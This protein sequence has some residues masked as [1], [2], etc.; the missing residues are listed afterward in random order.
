VYSTILLESP[1]TENKD[2]NKEIEQISSEPVAQ[3]EEIFKSL[4]EL[5]GSIKQNWGKYIVGGITV[6]VMLL[7]AHKFIQVWLKRITNQISAKN[8]EYINGIMR[9]LRSDSVIKS[10]FTSRKKVK[11]EI[12]RYLQ[13]LNKYNIS[14]QATP[15]QANDKLRDAFKRGKIT[16]REL[17]EFS[18]LTKKFYNASQIPENKAGKYLDIN[19]LVRKYEFKS[20]LAKT[21]KYLVIALFAIIA[22]GTVLLLVSLFEKL[23]PRPKEDNIEI[24][25][26]VLLEQKISIPGVLKD[27]ITILKNAGERFV[28]EPF[29][30][31]KVLFTLSAI[32]VG[33]L[34]FILAK[35]RV[36]SVGRRLSD[37]LSS[38]KDLTLDHKAQVL[39]GIMIILVSFV[40]YQFHQLKQGK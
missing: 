33:I 22:I 1:Q 25:E 7:I 19:S 30:N 13:I 27:I 37:F 36:G 34:A 28:I 6:S 10:L 40:I 17:D 38:L 12:A 5:F 4:L 29:K 26:T 15:Q 2:L 35:Y 9:R 16:S 39:I 11:E 20:K 24:E 14:P 23:I 21:D 3:P 8:E 32:G 18:K 31:H